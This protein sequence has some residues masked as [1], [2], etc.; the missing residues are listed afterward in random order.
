[1][2]LVKVIR[3]ILFCFSEVVF[4]EIAKMLH[5]KRDRKKSTPFQLFIVNS[6]FLGYVKVH[7]FKEV[8]YL[9]V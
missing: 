1:M 5:R 4:V 8:T 9:F 2:E 6:D 3:M 7:I